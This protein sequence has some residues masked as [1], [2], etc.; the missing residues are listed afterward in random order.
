MCIGVYGKHRDIIDAG[1]VWG[2]KQSGIDVY[3]SN[4]VQVH[5]HIHCL[6]FTECIQIQ[7]VQTARTDCSSSYRVSKNISSG[8]GRQI[9]DAEL[10]GANTYSRSLSASTGEG[11]QTYVKR[12]RFIL[13]S[14]NVT[15]HVKDLPSKCKKLDSKMRIWG[16]RL[17]MCQPW[18]PD[19]G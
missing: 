19:N 14:D 5:L 9:R 3:S 1:D 16:R 15:G 2:R 4:Y 17:E 8:R 7:I 18:I 13:Y 10:R 12:R 6:T 11:V